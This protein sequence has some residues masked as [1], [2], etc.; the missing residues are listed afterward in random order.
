MVALEVDLFVLSAE[1]EAHLL[2][3]T[4]CFQTFKELQ[5]VLPQGKRDLKETSLG[6]IKL[7]FLHFQRNF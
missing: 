4:E 3:V 2:N 5:E 7:C 1:N 6:C